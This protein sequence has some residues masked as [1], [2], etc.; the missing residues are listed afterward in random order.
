MSSFLRAFLCRRLCG[1]CCENRKEEVKSELSEDV[2]LLEVGPSFDLRRGLRFSRES[3][4]DGIERVC[5][6]PINLK[7]RTCQ[8][9]AFYEC[10]QL[11]NDNPKLPFL[12]W[13]RRLC[14]REAPMLL[15]GSLLE[16]P[17][18][19]GKF[20]LVGVTKGYRAWQPQ[21]DP[22]NKGYEVTPSDFC[23]AWNGE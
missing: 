14:P 23:R 17:L 7:G 6:H 21:T 18:S 13:C 11:Q 1:N 12:S 15:K 9:C 19:C 8:D 20:Q 22:S 3:C 16:E 5:Y 10:A 2:K 4:A